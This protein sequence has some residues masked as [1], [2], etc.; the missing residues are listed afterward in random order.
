[1]EAGFDKPKKETEHEL[2]REFVMARRENKQSRQDED[3]RSSTQGGSYLENLIREDVMAGRF[4]RPICTRF[5]PEPNGHLH[6]GSAYAIHINYTTA[7]TFEGT[8]HLRFD[9]T[10][11]LKEDISYVE[12][13]LKDMEW[14]GYSPGGHVYYGSDY[15]DRIYAAAVE[16]IQQGKAYVCHLSPEELAA[17]RGTLTE[18]GTDSPY[19][20]RTPEENLRL[21]QEMRNGIH[22]D[23]SC[24]LRAKI[25]M[26]SPNMNLRDPVLYRIIHAPHY[27]TGNVWCIYPMYDFAHPIQ[28]M[29][30]GITH[31]LCSIEFKDHRALYDW[32]LAELGILEPPRQ[33]EFGRVN[34]AGAV[35]GKRYLRKMVE[36]GWVDGWDD[37]RLPTISGLRR[38]G[39]T[40]ESIREFIGGI[41]LAR[42]QTTVDIS[43]LDHVLRQELKPNVPAIMAVVHPL[44]VI[45]INYPNEGEEMLPIE[46]NPL[47]ADRGVREVA[48]SR[49]LYID[50]DD[51][52]E[53]PAK[54]FHR[55][56]PG[57]EVRLKGAYFIRCEEVIKDPRSGE[58]IELHCTY[59]PRTKSGSGFKE[60]KVK[61]TIH[62][63]SAKH[64]VTCELRLYDQLLI[65]GV[66]LD[67]IGGNERLGMNPDSLHI[68]KQAVVEPYVQ[69]S[70]P[71][72]RFQFI[73]HGY[74]ILDS[75]NESSG[76]QFVFNRIVSLKDGWKR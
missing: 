61:G 67:D 73:R 70:N 17:S 23:G 45:L 8:F 52:M 65:P 69:Q 46:N 22:P 11:P 36:S 59:D 24:V 21:F 64:A 44:K 28:D 18:P 1:M 15:S 68:V 51:F 16:L 9:D 75:M 19:R 71:G 32:V 33:W 49:E 29:I 48:F 3:E 4:Q 41:G 13:I 47:T 62:W 5:P 25:D 37:P 50:R 66:N 10:N 38:R 42:Q 56:A 30:E 12:S 58:I 26:A 74:F 34:I 63:V 60:R 72:E 57:A 31:S 55:L 14:L 35:T 53:V 6:I 2:N 76:E 20:N 7:Q 39:Y 54:G 40:P 43:L 27:R